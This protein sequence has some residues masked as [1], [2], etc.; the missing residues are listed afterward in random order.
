[1]A[2]ISRDIITTSISLNLNISSWLSE[3]GPL[4]RDVLLGHLL[5]NSLAPEELSNS[6]HTAASASALA[7]INLAI[8]CSTWCRSAGVG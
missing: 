5:Q 7:K 2:K 6:T 3:K 8:S 1:M 4:K